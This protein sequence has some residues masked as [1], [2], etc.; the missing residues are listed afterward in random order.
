[1][2]QRWRSKARRDPDLDDA[3]SPSPA[4]PRA[5]PSDD[6]DEAGNEDLTLEIVARARRRGAAGGQPGLAEVLPLS[7]DEEVDEDAVVEL[8]EADPSRRKDKKKKKQR[9][10]ERRKKQRKEDAAAAAAAD[11]EEPQ[12]AGAQEGQTGT[13]ESVP[14]ENGVDAPVSDN[15]VLR[16]L[17]RIP[18]Y[19]DPGETILETCFNCGEE[20]HVAVN[21]PM[22]KRKKP[23]FVCGLFGH[24]AKQ[25][26]QGQECFICKKGGHM[27]KDCPDKHTKNTQQYTT[28][29][30]RC[31]ETGHDMFGCS[32]DYPPDDVKEIKCY[33]CN[34]NGHLCCTDFSD[35]CSKEVTC[36]NC[37]QSGHTGLGCA[38]QRR[39]TS[40][41]TTPTLCYKCGEDGHFARG[42]TNSAKPGRFKGE[43]SS[44]SRRK[45]KWKNDSG[46]RSAPH[47]SHKRK[48]PLFEDRWET[49]R[50]KSR[51]RGGW[52]PE[53]HDDLPS[54]KYKGNGWDSQSTP[55]KPYNNHHH[56]SSGGD[57]STPQ[58]QDFSWHNSQ[59]S[60]SAR[61]HGSSSS[62][63]ASN[64]HHR[65]ERS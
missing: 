39:E 21:C 28:L 44:H 4:R 26:T 14:T 6:E 61:K 31:G 10:K 50:G 9:R 47:G 53:D 3:G 7:S 33:V 22:E 27:A 23:C 38:K 18:R 56:R 8:G 13:V 58:G 32:N 48:S 29:C 37:A 59:Y 20:G 30:L 35:S 55:K 11:K 51:A 60:P 5:P 15:T 63:F 42:C 62:R 16:K 19:F 41:A 49:P 65:F 45:D 54:K 1:M 34:Q 17:L 24:N 57:Y 64:T 36:Y 25:C 43:L 52:I 12:V 2:A 40:V 46:P